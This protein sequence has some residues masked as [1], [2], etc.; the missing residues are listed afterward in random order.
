LAG[1]GKSHCGEKEHRMKM[2]EKATTDVSSLMFTRKY[3]IA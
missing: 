3:Y 1:K 2:K